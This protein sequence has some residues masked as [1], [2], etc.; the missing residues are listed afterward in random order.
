MLNIFSS[1]F[2]SLCACISLFIKKEFFRRLCA[3]K[4]CPLYI[5]MYIE[6]L[7][8][9]IVKLRGVEINDRNLIDVKTEIFCNLESTA[10]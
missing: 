9:R 8:I 4:M 10:V 5:F 7:E 3:F 6:E 1:F 2:L